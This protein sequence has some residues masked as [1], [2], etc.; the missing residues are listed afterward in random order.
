MVG[1]MSPRLGFKEGP[2]NMPA[3]AIQRRQKFIHYYKEQT[4]KSEINMRELAEFAVSMGWPLPKPI[5]PIDQLAKQFSEA[6]RE[7]TG[8]DKETKRPYRAALSITRRARDGR[9]MAFWFYVD[10]DPPRRYM[11]KGLYQYREQMV[12]EAVIATNT[13]D[14]WSRLHP[15]QKPLSFMTDLTPDVDERLNAPGDSG[16]MAS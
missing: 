15:D 2:T 12:G 9:Q 14:H 8:V 10:D 11:V 3:R 1:E 7:E 4:G 6:A 16:E 5:E 13:A